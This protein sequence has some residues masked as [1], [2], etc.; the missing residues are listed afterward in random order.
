MSVAVEVSKRPGV[1]GI[2]LGVKHVWSGLGDNAKKWIF[3]CSCFH[4]NECWTG[5][6]SGQH[7]FMAWSIS[8][9]TTYGFMA[10]VPLYQM[11]DKEFWSGVCPPTIH[12]G[13]RVSM[14]HLAKNNDNSSK[15][16]F[17]CSESFLATLI[18]DRLIEGVF[19]CTVN[20]W[21]WSLS[22]ESLHVHHNLPR[23]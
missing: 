23:Q 2:N 15:C 13:H 20:L 19:Y 18:H 17:G 7:R 3:E 10:N 16:G 14:L 8:W 22:L 6:V 5:P 9:P 21:F 1:S 4:L 12:V 11:Y